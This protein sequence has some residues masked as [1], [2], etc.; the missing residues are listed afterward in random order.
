MVSSGGE[1]ACLFLRIIRAAL[2][3]RFMIV[4]KAIRSHASRLDLQRCCTLAVTVD[5]GEGETGARLL[6]IARPS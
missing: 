2:D 4:S 5:S 3:P 1:R 6:I